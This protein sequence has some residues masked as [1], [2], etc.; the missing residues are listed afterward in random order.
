LLG[1]QLKLAHKRKPG[2]P[3]APKLS[4]VF[5][6]ELKLLWPTAMPVAKAAMTMTFLHCIG[7]PPRKSD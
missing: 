5:S 2:D 3:H 1:A 6:I 4:L 7:F